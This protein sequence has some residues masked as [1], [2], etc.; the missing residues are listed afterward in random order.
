MNANVVL[1]KR[2]AVADRNSVTL[3]L[4]LTAVAFQF[5]LVSE[6]PK[7]NYQTI[8]DWIMTIGLL[9]QLMTCTLVFL[10]ADNPHDD[11]D[12]SLFYELTDANVA[13]VEN[14]YLIV[15]ILPWIAGNM[16]LIAIAKLDLFS[17]N[18]EELVFSGQRWLDTA[19][20]VDAHGLP[21]GEYTLHRCGVQ[22][23]S[24]VI[25]LNKPSYAPVLGR[26]ALV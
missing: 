18:F 13:F 19:L 22:R 9:V 7:K 16:V 2:N 17:I 10:N 11:Q 1:I 12:R 25:R 14:G 3:T 4:L 21:S 6:V 26:N 24:E 23:T 20:G 15:F 5:L 8:L